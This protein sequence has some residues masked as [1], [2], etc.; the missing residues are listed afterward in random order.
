L[1]FNR[2]QA[3][4]SPFLPS[5]KCLAFS[6]LNLFDITIC[7]DVRCSMLDCVRRSLY[8]LKLSGEAKTDAQCS[9]PTSPR[10]R[11]AGSVSVF[12]ALS[13]GTA[14]LWSL[15]SGLQSSELFPPLFLGW[16]KRRKSAST[17]QTMGIVYSIAVLPL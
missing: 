9:F 6:N 10:L 2:R 12:T 5:F 3:I 17:R 14:G 1:F 4:F 13:R 8:H 16:I 15:V 7:F 11:W